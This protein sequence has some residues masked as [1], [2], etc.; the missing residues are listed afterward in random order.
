MTS[1]KL[2]ISRGNASEKVWHCTR[3][4]WSIKAATGMSE[5]S[6]KEF[7]RTAFESHICGDYK[8]VEQDS[9]KT[10]T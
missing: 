7:A 9:A 3:C 2:L 1:S 8:S 10:T 6:A 4:T 5:K